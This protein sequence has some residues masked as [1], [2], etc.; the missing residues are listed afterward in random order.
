MEYTLSAYM[1]ADRN[2]VRVRMKAGKH[3]ADAKV[4]TEWKRYRCKATLPSRI[5]FICNPTGEGG[6]ATVWIDALQLESGDTP[7]AFKP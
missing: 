2:G 4:T 3:Y 1:L 6:P 7:T 5:C